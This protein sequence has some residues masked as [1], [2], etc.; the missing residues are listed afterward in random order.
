MKNLMYT[1]S[2]TDKNGNKF[3]SEPAPGLGFHMQALMIIHDVFGDHFS[4]TIES[5]DSHEEEP[6]TKLVAQL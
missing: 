2:I 6:Q 5:Y 3:T 1:L 4:V